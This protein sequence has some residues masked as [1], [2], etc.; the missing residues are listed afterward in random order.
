MA[1]STLSVGIVG[2]PNVGKSTLFQA[3][4]KK[5]VDTANYPFCTVDPNI[6]IVKVPDERLQKLADFFES[7]KVIPTIVEFVDIAGLV[8][9]ANK[10]E[11]LGNQFLSNIREVDAIVQVVRCFENANITHV[12]ETIDPLRDIDT[13]QTELLLKDLETLQ[14]RVSSL[15]KD[16]R[17]KNKE[18]IAAQEML[19]A[20]LRAMNEG[21]TAFQFIKEN[22][23]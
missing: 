6:G 7:K 5:K 2:L 11:G 3:L 23:L 13:I 21:V 1:R 15:E 22:P 9:G 18:A 4:T 10:G 17:S 12:D 8:K 14:K 20:L 19:Q 16:V